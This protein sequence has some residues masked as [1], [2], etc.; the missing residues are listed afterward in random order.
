MVSEKITVTIPQDLKER[1]VEIKD[2]LKTTMSSV[3]REALEDYLEKKELEKWE[4][5]ATLASKD[6]EYKANSE[7]LINKK[8]EVYEY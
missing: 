4:K 8:D 2:E 5:G 3:Y 6:K 1:L 7:D